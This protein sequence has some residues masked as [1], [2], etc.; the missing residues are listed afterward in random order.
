[1]LSIELPLNCLST[2][3]TLPE[4]IILLFFCCYYLPHFSIQ[5]NE[6]WFIQVRLNAFQSIQYLTSWLAG[7]GCV[8]L[9]AV[10]EGVAV[11]VMDDLA[12][13]ERS[14]WE[15]WHEVHHGRLS[16][17][18]L[19]RIIHEEKNFIRRDLSTPTK[20]VQV[21]WHPEL[22]P[23]ATKIFLKLTT[24]KC[25]CEFV[26]E[27]LLKFTTSLHVGAD[28]VT[29]DPY[30]E[31]FDYYFERCGSVPFAK[32]MAQCAALDLPAVREEILR[33]DKEAIKQAA[34]FHGD[35]GKGKPRLDKMAS[36]E[37]QLVFQ[38]GEEVLA[39]LAADGDT[40]IAKFGVKFLVAAKGKSGKEL[41]Q[42]L[43]QRMNNSEAEELENARQAL[44]EIT[45]QRIEADPPDRLLSSLESLREAHKVVGAS[46]CISLGAAEEQCLCLGESTA[47]GG[48]VSPQCRFQIASLSK[49]IASCFCMEYFH[50]KGISLETSVNAVLKDIGASY[51]LNGEYGDQVNLRHLM[52]HAALNMHYVNGIP[53]SE[54]M[55]STADLLQG[56]AKYNYPKLA[57]VAAPGTEFHY[58]GG[59]FLLLQHIIETAES[60]PVS[61]VLLPFLQ[62]LGVA[63]ELS[64]AE[65]CDDKSDDMDTP[66]GTEKVTAIGYRE[67]GKPVKDGRLKFPAFAAGALATPRAVLRFLQ[68]LA[69]AYEKPSVS[70]TSA[71]P[72]ANSSAVISHD[73][74]VEMV[75]ASDKGCMDFMGCRMGVGVFVV[76]AGPNRFLVHQGANDGFRAI[77][78]YCFDGPAKHKGVVVCA[79]GDNNAMLFIA[80]AMR[81]LMPTLDV[82]GVNLEK[83]RQNM[84]VNLAGVPQEEIVNMGYKALLFE[85]FAP[86][87]PP[88]IPR[89]IG[90]CQKHPMAERN[91][92]AGAKILQV[93]NQRFARAENV[94]S[95]YI[96]CFDPK[97]F[98]AMGKVMDSWETARH[99]PEGVDFLVARIPQKCD[100]QYVEISTRYHLGNQV[101]AVKVKL[102]GD[103]ED[104][105]KTAV[106][107]FKL[108]GHAEVFLRLSEKVM[109]VEEIM[110]EIFP[111]GGLSRVALYDDDLPPDYAEK[112]QLVESAKSVPC[113]E[114][115]PQ[116]KKP[117]QLIYHSEEEE[118]RLNWANAKLRGGQVE[119]SSLGF[120]GSLV[121]VTNEHYG[122]AAQ[123][124][125]PYMPLSM[126]DGFESARS[127]QKGHVEELVLRLGRPAVLS[128][129]EFDFAFFVNN[130]P[131]FVQVL[132]VADGEGE[133]GEKEIVPKTSVKAFAGNVKVFTV[134]ETSKVELLKVKVFPDGGINRI[135]AFADISQCEWMEKSK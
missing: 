34:S 48:A 81:E 27:V 121:S 2:G 102:R 45:R 92:A 35:I 133:T 6:S 58:S 14:R 117:L 26:T 40:Y 101:E 114:E 22:T 55:P 43:R 106:D 124:L 85:A 131:M 16:V 67:D 13:V 11:R 135:R 46:L 116:T 56:N 134:S 104:A 110:L 76:E 73:I 36:K 23:L 128:R 99:N 75:H 105:W 62:R 65:S 132:S 111:D 47:G 70:A 41:L 118:V 19:V 59:G 29:L 86:T 89:T 78:L 32:K 80:K 21:A 122:P 107:S 66:N 90:S 24:D 96:P 12:T 129:I 51:R 54:A 38:E 15:V 64:F 20:R 130:N 53:L 120:G 93:S 49:T 126:H 31:R 10:V 77:F 108:E 123:V 119:V 52:S 91:L 103:G 79:N 61:Q 7:N 50:S 17:P 100:V 88:P 82:E 8:A 1:M 83:L 87:L 5:T 97:A 112:F 74:A 94:F 60:K 28:R 3:T 98:C 115:I 95:P 113:K 84:D 57:V 63:E 69:E 68:A 18:T 33:F 4:T 37:Q 30:V 71:A 72:S 39:A 42:L 25:P 125:S 44:W 109:Q 127:R 9:P